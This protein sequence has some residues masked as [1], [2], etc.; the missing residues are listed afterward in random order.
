M[1]VSKKAKDINLLPESEA[2][3][4]AAKVAPVLLIIIL[5]VAVV[6][7]L[8][9]G[10]TFLKI[11]SETQN[12]ELEE[13]LASKNQEWQKVAS[14]AASLSQIKAK[15]GSYQAYNLQYPD[16]VAHIK[17]LKVQLPNPASLKTL[18]L[19]NKGVAVFQVEMDSPA[20]AYQMVDLLN[21]DKNFSNVKLTSISKTSA[22]GSY[23]I[24]ITLTINK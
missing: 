1:L 22:D 13:S 3:K 5:I 21:Q 14:A 11:S 20:D 19:D 24:N 9:G 12:Q 4:S 18:N 8:S 2:G 6:A 15:L 23:L 17:K 7:A 10:V 16:L